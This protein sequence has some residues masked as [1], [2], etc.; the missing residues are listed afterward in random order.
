MRI[1]KNAIKKTLHSF[2][3]ELKK[4]VAR[5]SAPVTSRLENLFIEARNLGFFPELIFDIGANHGSWTTQILSIFPQ[6]KFV[7]FEPQ[8][9]CG[10]DILKALQ[11]SPIS[12][13]R[14]AA[15]AGQVGKQ[16]FNVSTWDVTSSLISTEDSVSN[17]IEVEVTT[18]D[19]EAVRENRVPD[20]L[21]IDAEGYDLA[22]LEGASACLGQIEVVL[23]EAG[24]LCSCDNSVQAVMEKMTLSGYGLIGIVDLNPLQSPDGKMN[25][26]RLWLVDL[27]FALKSGSLYKRFTAEN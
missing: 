5:H 2:G 23:V 8:S 13:W 6:A 12:S 3:F 7:L 1:I 15:V 22:V 26:G 14:Q 21:K 24:V 11:S 27:V 9:H 17:F 16:K 10:P 20:I 4:S 19:A 25:E 18:V